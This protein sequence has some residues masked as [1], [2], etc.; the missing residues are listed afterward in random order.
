MSRLAKKPLEIPEKVEVKK[1]GNCV[2]VKGP[3]GT[4]QQE[5]DPDIEVKIEDSKIWVK[6]PT[7]QKRHKALQGLYWSLIRNMLIGV[8]KG[9]EK[10]LE[11]VGIGYRAKVDK[12]GLHL[13]LGF[14]HNILFVPPP[15]IKIETKYEKGGNPTVI[16]KGIDK[17]LVGQ[18]AAYIRSLRPP[19]PYK[20]KGI[21]YVGEYIRRKEGKA[22]RK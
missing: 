20:G 8:T 7:D 3:L 9:Y 18:V 11:L 22:A 6:R 21:R 16:V 4:L 12:L 10:Q 14:S 17:Q 5:I 13:F 2:I 19:E 15:E 1:E